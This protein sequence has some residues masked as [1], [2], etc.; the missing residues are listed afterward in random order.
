MTKGGALAVAYRA[1]EAATERQGRCARDRL[2]AEGLPSI[3]CK[4][5]APPEQIAIAFRVLSETEALEELDLPAFIRRGAPLASTAAGRI[6]LEMPLVV[7]EGFPAQR[8]A[9]DRVDARDGKEAC[10]VRVG[11]L[12]E[13]PPSP[14]F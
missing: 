7:D 3:L 2:D 13:R 14:R 10:E 12:A 9:D 1:A 4:A 11:Q 8:V 5:R 6:A